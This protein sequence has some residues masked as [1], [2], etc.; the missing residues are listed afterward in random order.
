MATK[1][2]GQKEATPQQKPS[3]APR[4]ARRERA[5]AEAEQVAKRDKELLKRLSK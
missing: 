1:S 4:V 2:K 5:L 3:A